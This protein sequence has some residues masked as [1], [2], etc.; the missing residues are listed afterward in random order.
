MA[1][2]G[3]IEG[4]IGWEGLENCTLRV[5]EIF[6]WPASAGHRECWVERTEACDEDRNSGGVGSETVAIARIPEG[7]AAVV[8]EREE[9]DWLWL[10]GHL[11]G[12]S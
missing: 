5:L 6:A 11:N 9:V 12:E 8:V 7:E 2:L 4:D 3:K 1:P 10:I